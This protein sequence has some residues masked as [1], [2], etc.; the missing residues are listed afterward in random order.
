MSSKEFWEY[1]RKVRLWAI[2]EHNFN[3]PDPN[4]PDQTQI[5]K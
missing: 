3:I 2:V 1:I 5:A 4:K